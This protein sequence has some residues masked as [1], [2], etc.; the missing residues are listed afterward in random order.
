[1]GR[2]IGP[3]GWRGVVAGL[4]KK[5]GSSWGLAVRE[6]GS[7]AY[8]WVLSKEAG[9]QSFRD[10]DEVRVYGQLSKVSILEIQVDSTRIVTLN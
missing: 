10:G 2:N 5:Q 8:L 9:A 4:P 1:M 6:I 7:D 3:E